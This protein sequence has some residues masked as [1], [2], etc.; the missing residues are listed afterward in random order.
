VIF[1]LDHVYL[2][3]GLLLGFV[4][5]LTALDRG[6]PRRYTSALF[7]GLYAA[8]YLAGDFM[9]PALAGALMIAMALL[10]GCGG[11]GR[12]SMARWTKRIAVPARRA[13]ATACSCRRW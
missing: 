6:H 4:A 12:A 7:W 10:A 11:V 13:W 3:V 5:L 1:S 2:L 9:A 8:V